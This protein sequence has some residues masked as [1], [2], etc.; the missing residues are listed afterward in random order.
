MDWPL[1]LTFL[2]ACAA[3]AASGALFTPGDWYK[4]L[5]KPRW[6]PPNW[7]FPVVWAFLYVSMAAAAA[8]IAVLPGT[9]QALGFWAIQ[10]AFNTLWSGVFFGLHR[11]AAAGLILGALWLAVCTGMIAFWQ[12]DLIAGALFV[13][14]LIWVS[15]AFALNWSVW[16]RNRATV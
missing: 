5:S 1:F 6:T 3:P 13:P 15:I 10:I 16:A 4:S 9:G 2:A 14:Y 12:H 11:M 7:L 8:R